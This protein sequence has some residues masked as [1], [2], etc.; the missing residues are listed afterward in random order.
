[1]KKRTYISALLMGLLLLGTGA[2]VT[3]CKDYDD[4]INNLQTQIDN[5][6]KT[7]D[8]I[9][10]QITAGSI[11]TKVENTSTGVKISLSNGQSYDINNGKDGDAWTIQDGYWYQNG[12]K[13]EYKAVGENGADGADGKDGAYY[14]PNADGYF[15]K[16]TA[17]GKQEK[18]DI[19]WKVSNASNIYAVMDATD[20]T[21]YNVPDKNG[22]IDPNGIKISLSNNLRGLVFEKDTKGRVYVDGVPGIRVTSFSY[23]AQTLSGINSS[24]EKATASS[25]E[26]VVNP[27]TYAYYHVNPANA[28]IKDLE[29]L[30]YVVKANADYITS[31]TPASDDFDAKGEFVEFKDGILKVKVNVTG[32]PA[33]AEKISVAALQAKKRNNETITSDYTTFYRQAM[34]GL[35][36]ADKEKFSLAKPVDYHYRRAAV[37][38]NAI[39][40]EAGIPDKAVWSTQDG[41][42]YD[43]EVQYDG[44]I[45]LSTKVGVHELGAK[46]THGVSICTPADLEALG[47]ALKYEVVQN[48][49]IG[50]NQ[51]DQKDFITM[52]GSVFTPRV[53]SDTNKYAAVGRT[54][55]IRVSLIDTKN[56]N[57]VVEY[58]YIKL[59]IVKAEVENKEI[60][61]TTDNFKFNCTTDYNVKTTVEQTNVQLYNAMNM[62][63]IE[64]HATY[65]YF[66]AQNNTTGNVG[67]VKELF[68][69]QNG[70]T[71]HLIQWTLTPNEM[72]ELAGKQVTHTVKYM[73]AAGSKQFV[74]IVLKANVDNIQ[75]E[76]NITTSQYINEYWNA[77]KTYA[78][79]NVATPDKGSTDADR[80]I[81]KNDLNSP[82]VT[83][84][85]KLKLDDAI[86][87]RTFAFDRSNEAIT[88]V[89]NVNVKFTVIKNGEGLDA[90][91]NGKT[92]EVATIHNDGAGVPYNYV[93][94]NKNSDIAKLLLN[95]NEFDV[96]YSIKA[97]V[98]NDANKVVTVKFNGK[99]YFTARFLQPVKITTLS[100]DYFV[101]ALDFGV[102]HTY[103]AL[104]DLIAPVDWRGF[105]FKDNAN[106]WDYYGVF[107]ITPDLENAE[108]DL[109]GVRAKVP[110]TIQLNETKTQVGADSKFGFVTYRNNGTNVQK[111]FN[112]YIKVNV[113]YG[114]G[115]IQTDFIKVPV[116]PTVGQDK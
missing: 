103:L 91:V 89:G 80:C 62:D 114:W 14:V 48:Y 82:F 105:S 90:T 12:T 29:D 113:E 31:R 76:Y 115:V 81:F 1:M 77:E 19:S 85:G 87:N 40:S 86:T 79:F 10:S 101:D 35:R 111:E 54:P 51:T 30:G 61:F 60:G 88:K 5:L 92:E 74:T 13:T 104:E 98:C 83:V 16:V 50:S 75:K 45:D 36:L 43:Y 70:E 27:E 58:A 59:K 22:T 20:L 110:A 53:F 42:D 116:K 49:K 68:D 66:D 6:Q 3:S 96:N 17:D 7:I 95:T 93:E 65:P 102:E 52:N 78:K 21:L 64:F 25:K 28:N 26:T 18:T 23:G 100:A 97:N 94:L 56:N 15:Y 57:Q 8:Q 73:T 39:D 37:G 69:T 2:S 84:D 72:W 11:I 4:D 67:I 112:L 109:N 33:T 55:I 9:N 107:R 44:S 47:F 71:T 63:R 106:Y 108:C 46:D 41:S 32:T 38:I 24:A 99:D 34:N